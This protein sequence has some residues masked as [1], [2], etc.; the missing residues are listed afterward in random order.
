MPQHR[1]VLRTLR[2]AGLAASCLLAVGGWLGGALPDSNLAATPV[3]IWRAPY[4]AFILAGWLA[5]TATLAY[6]WWVAR[7][8]LPST[9]WVVVTVVL[10]LLPFVV[11]PPM[12]SRDVYSYACQGD[13]FRHGLNPY[14]AGVSALPCQWIDAVSPVWRDTPTPYGPLFVLLTA[15][16]VA[17]G[18]TLPG[19]IVLLRLVTVAA[20]AVIA[21]SLPVLARRCGVPARRAL[22]VALAGPLVGPQLIAGMH[23]DALML[24]LMVGGLAL[25]VAVPDRVLVW[26]AGAALLGLATA[27]KATAIVV[28]PFAVLIAVRG[29]DRPSAGRAVR[30]GAIVVGGAAVGMALVTAASGLGF[31]WVPAM[32]QT[33]NLIQFTSLPSAVG[34]T[35]TYIVRPVVPGVDAVPAVRM[36]AIGL[37]AVLLVGLWLRAGRAA[38]PVPAALW[39]AALAMAATVALSPAFHPW[40]ALWPLMLMAATTLRTDLVMAAA[41]GAD[42]IVLPDGSGL[43]RFVKFPGA[44]LMT[45]VIVVLLV[46]Y[47]RGRARPASP[48]YLDVRGAC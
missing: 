27:V 17:L 13:L 37:L 47:V 35:V 30:G 46:R 1:C 25:L 40:Y 23:N 39:G 36:L 38:D 15:A 4:G 19:I 33:G 45:A 32:S 8:R 24:A 31:G 16:V 14:D 43:A 3:T 29:P 22:W 7:D 11:V 20:V 21:L 34:M 10:W 5:G 18:G 44:P 41:I 42:L 48:P 2:Y 6:L 28:L 9:R 12:G 26:L